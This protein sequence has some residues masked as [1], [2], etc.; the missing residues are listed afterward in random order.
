MGA[1]SRRCSTRRWSTPPVT[2]GRWVTT[3]ELTVRFSKPARTG[4]TL[5][6]SAEVVRQ[7]SRLVECRAEA[8]D[9]EGQLLATATGKL[10]QSREL[11]EGEAP[12][13]PEA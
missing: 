1:S 2:L 9:S 13:R 5:T 10:M 3:A 11:R 7:R 12:G 8:R 4:D 6:L